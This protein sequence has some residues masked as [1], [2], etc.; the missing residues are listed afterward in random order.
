[1]KYAGEAAAKMDGKPLSKFEYGQYLAAAL[2]YLLVRQQD[3]VGEI[4]GGAENVEREDEMDGHGG[5][6][7]PVRQP[8]PFIVAIA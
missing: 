6:I 1:M 3:A 2:T 5:A 7:L 4:A 8:L